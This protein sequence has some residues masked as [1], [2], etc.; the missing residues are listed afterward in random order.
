MEGDSS[1]RQITGWHVLGGFVLG[2]GVIIGVNTYM[3]VSAVKTFPGLEVQSSY[4]ASQTFDKD[5]AAQ[6]SL[7]WKVHAVRKGDEL[8]LSVRHD[9]RP[10]E[11]V[12]EMAVVGRATTEAQDHKPDFVFDGQDFVAHVDFEP[13][14][15]DLRLLLRAEDGTLYRKRLEVGAA[16]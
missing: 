14:N 8:R 2:F 6:E 7:G 12:I 4:V 1:M 16:S 3:A 10:V 13:G 9:G 15:W 11:P 5:R